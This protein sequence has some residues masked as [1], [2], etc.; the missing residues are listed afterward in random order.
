MIIY[1]SFMTAYI[2]NLQSITGYNIT[3]IYT[4]FYRPPVTFVQCLEV[5]ICLYSLYVSF[6]GL[7]L[8]KGLNKEVQQN[9]FRRQVFFVI[10]R[11]VTSI[12]FTIQAIDEFFSPKRDIIVIYE[13][14]KSNH[15]TVAQA[16]SMCR[17]I[18][19]FLLVCLDPEFRK[20]CKK[21]VPQWCF[22]K[23]RHASVST[24]NS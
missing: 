4:F 13:I 12:P 3:G 8:R 17:G 16:L 24:T 5:F 2:P 23:D 11:V 1:T 22:R 9:I 20:V 7:C 21:L 15:T 19:Y 18:F 6:I 14:P 10:I